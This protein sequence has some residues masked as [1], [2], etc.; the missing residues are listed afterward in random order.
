MAERD[1]SPD[2]GAVGVTAAHSGR[3]AAAGR[4]GPC[5]VQAACASLTRRRARGRRVSGGIPPATARRQAS[6]TWRRSTV[7]RRRV[8]P[9]S[10]VPAGPCG[11]GAGAR[12]AAGG[13]P[14]R[15]PERA[16]ARPCQPAGRPRAGSRRRH[17][18]GSPVQPTPATTSG[19]GVVA[20][21]EHRRRASRRQ[22]EGAPQEGSPP[23]RQL[24]GRGRRRRGGAARQVPAVAGAG[25]A[26]LARCRWERE[27]PSWGTRQLVCAGC[28]RQTCGAV[29]GWPRQAAGGRRGSRRSRTRG[30]R[31]RLAV[32]AVVDRPPVT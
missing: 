18:T 12:R 8:A 27:R 28:D 13:G 5:C 2:P 4:R 31:C 6:V 15:A 16:S 24:R 30:S 26:P 3:A 9:R 19:G 23:P 1:R 14:S 20:G 17:R 21:E 25:V 7:S 11:P 10:S 32:A 29:C 22:R